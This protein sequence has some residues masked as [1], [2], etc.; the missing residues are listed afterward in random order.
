VNHIKRL[1]LERAESLKKLAD[2]MER[3][4]ELEVYLASSKFEAGELAGYVNVRD[5]QARLDLVKRELM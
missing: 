2:A 4:T 5:V 3:I 1:Q